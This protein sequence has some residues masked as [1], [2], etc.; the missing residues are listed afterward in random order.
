VVK[1][2]LSETGPLAVKTSWVAFSVGGAAHLMVDCTAETFASVRRLAEHCDEHGY[3][4]DDVVAGIAENYM[5]PP[6]Q[7]RAE[8]LTA[9]H[10]KART[11]RARSAK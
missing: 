4:M 11:S 3:R 6:M 2:V 10:E 5:A 1:L 7:V 8:T 9:E